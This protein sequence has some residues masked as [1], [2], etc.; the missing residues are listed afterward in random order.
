MLLKTLKSVKT[1]VADVAV[2]DVMAEVADIEVTLA[3]VVMAVVTE[4]AVRVVAVIKGAVMAVVILVLKGG[5]AHHGVGAVPLLR[6]REV[7][8]VHVMAVP[9]KAIVI[10]IADH[11][12]H[13]EAIDQAHLVVMQVVLQNLHHV[14]LTK[15]IKSLLLLAQKRQ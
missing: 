9:T 3:G 15:K 13:Q 14:M 10:P 2:A 8:Q 6:K 7:Q 11:H 1:A 12:A 4:E 5:I